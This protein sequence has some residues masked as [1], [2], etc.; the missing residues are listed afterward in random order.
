M[1]KRE[2]II[3]EC[4]LCKKEIKNERDLTK[5]QLPYFD[6]D[7]DYYFGYADEYDCCE[8]CATKIA[9]LLGKHIGYYDE[10]KGVLVAR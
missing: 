4:D 2:I 1:A 8:E 7:T 10:E 3:Y 5:V 6:E 9:K